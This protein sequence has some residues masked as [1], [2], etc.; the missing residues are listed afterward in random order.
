MAIFT[1]IAAAIGLTGFFATA[2]V[3]VAG[4]ATSIGLS[5]AAK[6]LAGTP[7]TPTASAAAGFS[8]QG[9]LQAA[10]DV[11]RSFNV[12]YSVTAGSLVYPNTW[13]ASGNTPNAYLTQ[14]ISLADL[15]GGALQEVWV[16][17]ALCT[18]GGVADANLGYPVTQYNKGGVDHLWVKYYNGTQ[19]TADAFL[20]STFGTDPNYPYQSTRVG[21]GVAY[22][23]VTALVDDTLFT[24]FPTYKFGLSGI[25]LYDPTK[26]S[27]NGGTGTHLWSDPT[28]WG[29]DGDQFPAVQIYNILRGFSYGGRWLYGLQNMTAARLPAINWNAQIA[30]CRATITGVSGL[31]PTYRSGGQINVNA[32]IANTVEALLTACQGKISEIGGFYKIH[33]GAPDSPSFSFTDD[34]ILSTEIQTFTPFFG[35]ADSINGI[36]A[37]YSDPIQGWNSTVAPPLYVPAY[38]AQDGNRRLLA[39]PSFDFVPYPAQVQRLM[40]SALSEARRARQHAIVMPPEFWIVEPGDVGTWTST[41]NGYVAKQFRVDGTIDKANLDT[42]FSLTEVDPTD[43][44]WNHAVDFTSPTSGPTIIARPAPQGIIA[45][46][47]TASIIKDSNGISRRPAIALSWDGTVPGVIGVQFEVRLASDA[48]SVTRGRTDQLAAGTLIISQSLL[49]NT[50]Y[51]VRGQ[52]IPSAPRD[53][54]WSGWLAVT[55]PDVRESLVDFDASIVFQVTTVLDQL[56]DVKNQAAQIIASLASNDIARNWLDKKETKSELSSQIGLTNA[57]VTQVQTT[58]VSATQAIASLTTSVTAQF[59]AVNTV[60]AAN[61]AGISDE[62]VARANADSALATNIK[63]L[64]TTVGGHTASLQLVASSVNGNSVYLGLIGTIDGVTGGLVLTGVGNNGVVSYNLYLRGNFIVDG[65]ITASKMNIGSLS[66][67]NANLGTV[68]AGLMQSPDGKF[69]IDLTNRRI[70]ISDNS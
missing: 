60:A 48:S 1:A 17:G 19:T 61:T 45:W 18:L 26:D 52:Y 63:S 31:E 47:A 8:V 6:A 29:G 57:Q 34:N 50:A 49:P 16:N 66:A 4:I 15:P 5:Y 24:G 58:A 30:K 9:T 40:K 44:N 56:N 42:G 10:G 11:P 54:L 51:E 3:T 41:R 12:G 37:S 62:T 36:T 38:E 33:L 59:Q 28:T 53:M 65:T 32:Q 14:V 55:T 64:S 2:F 67:I 46:F 68:T 7:D 35:L 23:I 39:N 21:K 70:V 22:V 27:T 25:P 43:Y 13:G 69:V 20:V